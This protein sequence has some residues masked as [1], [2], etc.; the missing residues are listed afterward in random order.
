MHERHAFQDD[1]VAVSIPVKFDH[2]APTGHARVD[3]WRRQIEAEQVDLLYTQLRP[4]LIA[5]TLNVSL[6]TL[7]LWNVIAH[8]LLLIW[9]AAMLVG[10]ACRLLS[11]RWYRQ[12]VPT[13]SQMR[14]WRR[15]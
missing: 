13:A 1:P 14:T 12:T 11:V 5:S 4:A 2:L 7:V 10:F 15:R 3:R 9:T 6:V 8:L